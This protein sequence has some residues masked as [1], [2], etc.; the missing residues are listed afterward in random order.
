ML[1]NSPDL[2]NEHFEVNFHE[3]ILTNIY[4][5]DTHLRVPRQPFSYTFILISTG[6]ATLEFIFA[7]GKGKFAPV[8]N[9]TP[10]VQE[11]EKRR[12]QNS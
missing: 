6:A 10:M 2:A 9:I 11:S 1:M 8:E 4:F 5:G 12:A 7:S 3:T